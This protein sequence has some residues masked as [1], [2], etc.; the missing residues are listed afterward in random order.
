MNSSHDALR[1][2]RNSATRERTPNQAHAKYHHWQLP[3]FME[4]RGGGVGSGLTV[5]GKYAIN[6]KITL[7]FCIFLHITYNS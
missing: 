2:R 7:K 6:L 4:K 3:T 5:V 1:M